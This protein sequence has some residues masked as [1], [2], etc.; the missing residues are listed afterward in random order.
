MTIKMVALDLDGT[1]LNS[2]GKL[3]PHTKDTLEKAIERGVQVV[4]STGRVFSSIP[5][6]VLAVKGIDYAISSNGAIISDLR[7]GHVIYGDYLSEEA[8]LRS[9]EIADEHNI[10]LEAFWGGKAYMDKGF[11]EL[12]EREG[13]LNRNKDYVLR[14]RIPLGNLFDG[15]RENIDRI[16]N[17]NFFF[18]QIEDLEKHRHEIEAIPNAMKTSSFSNN[19][20]VGGPG[21][22][23][24]KAIEALLD[25][26][27]ISQSELMCCGDAPNDIEMIKFAGLGVAMGNA[28]GDTKKYADYVTATNDE[29][30]V[31]LAIEKFCF[32]QE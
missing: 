15:M 7:K 12:I 9:I 6:E 24:R 20:E 17:L 27:G 22:C 11:Y 25:K 1:T 29:D 2:K 28:W 10:M 18:S 3:S 32:G 31:A 23:K 5:K 4:V 19:L 16:E 14:T 26:K 8:V 30:G 21:T 13:C